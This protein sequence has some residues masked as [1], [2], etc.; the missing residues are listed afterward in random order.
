MLSNFLIISVFRE[1][2]R[3]KT[4]SAIRT[5]PPTLTEEII[6]NPPLVVLKTTKNLSM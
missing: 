2:D 3:V 1:K 4:A 5:G 6:Q